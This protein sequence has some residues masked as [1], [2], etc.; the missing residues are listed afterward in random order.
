MGHSGQLLGAVKSAFSVGTKGLCSVPADQGRSYRT[1]LLYVS[2]KLQ[3]AAG[4]DR[5]KKMCSLK[6]TT[7]TPKLFE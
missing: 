5:G 1:G 4:R 2:Q 3:I 6:A 7:D